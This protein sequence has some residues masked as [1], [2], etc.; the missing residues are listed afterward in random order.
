MKIITRNLFG[1]QRAE[2]EIAIITVLAGANYAGK[3]SLCRYIAAALAGRPI[4]IA[5]IK[6]QDSALFLAPGCTEGEIAI[7]DEPHGTITLAFP[8]AARSSEGAP[9]EISAYAAGID[10][11]LSGNELAQ[12]PT[13]KE[14]LKSRSE[15]ICELLQ[16]APTEADLR[17]ALKS[18]AEPVIVRLWQTI[19][20]QGWDAAWGGAKEKGTK[21][22]GQWEAETQEDYGA[23]K[24]E[25]WLPV[26]YTP[27]LDALTAEQLQAEV[28]HEQE[29]LEAA[30]S[31][32]AVSASEIARLQAAAEPA[33][34]LTKDIASNKTACE[35]I[36]KNK[37]ELA[38]ALTKLPPATQHDLLKCPCCAADLALEAGK[39]IKPVVLS[40]IEIDRRQKT[41]DDT[42]NA[43][44]L[45]DGELAK[46][47]EYRATLEAQLRTAQD[48]A[49]KLGAKGK[50]PATP[51]GGKV[52]E[53]RGRLKRAQERLEAWNK[54]QNST[55]LA[56]QITQNKAIADILAPD[57]LRLTKLR[58][59]LGRINKTL[60]ELCAIAGWGRVEIMPNLAVTYN[61]TML[62]LVSKSELY[63]TQ[64]ALQIA[65]AIIDTS[66]MVIIDGAD[67]LDYVG[68]NGLIKMLLAS[69]KQ[70]IVAMTIDKKERVPNLSKVGGVAYWITNG[71]TE[72]IG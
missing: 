12:K 19:Q 40:Q 35:A 55:K 7:D 49:K 52:E 54:R 62:A 68:R 26:G 10:S 8:A 69:Q 45:C 21:L 24:A 66:A 23:K 34:Q 22:K 65:H 47:S 1:A 39:L 67:I 32:E 2:I 36:Q 28:T 18:L 59:A 14:D 64:V 5:G 41:L 38:E 3:S 17:K 57:G 61:Q 15:V 29:W 11:L 9:T 71:V 16:S 60:A 63:R 25:T 56:A 4:P 48:A 13:T 37:K 33:T 44:A 31:S 30:I 20:A 72:R 58:D 70:A 43:I 53:I 51:A 27:D 50:A 42:R 46:Q 6:K